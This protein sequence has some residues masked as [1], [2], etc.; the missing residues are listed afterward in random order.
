MPYPVAKQKTH[1]E[2]VGLQRF[3]YSKEQR[4]LTI[5]SEYFGMPE[6]F[7]VISHHTGRIVTFAVV[8]PGDNLFCQDGWDGEQKIYRPIDECKGVDYCVIYNAY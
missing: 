2:V 1:V 6:R 4:K 8:Q 3:E 7:K 5:P